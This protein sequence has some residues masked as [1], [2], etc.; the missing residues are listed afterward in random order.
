M[1]D[2]AE[3]GRLTCDAYHSAGAAANEAWAGRGKA[4]TIWLAPDG[5]RD[6]CSTSRGG[7]ER[8]VM[9]KTTN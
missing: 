3:I 8:S 6:L 9:G 5:G 4:T 7:L 1:L 2:R